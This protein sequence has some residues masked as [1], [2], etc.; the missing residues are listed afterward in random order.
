MRK[1]YFIFTMFFMGAV[2]AFAQGDDCANA[3]N[4][5]PASYVSDG[6]SSGNGASTSGTHSDWYKFTPLCDGIMSVGS[7]GGGVDT[8][9]YV[10]SGACGSLNQVGYADDNCTMGPGQS[11]FASTVVNLSVTGG[12]TYFI[13]W[14]DFWSSAPTPWYLD[15]TI[16]GGVNS[17]LVP[18]INEGYL[19]WIANGTEPGWDIQYGPDGFALGSGTSVN[20]DSAQG[21][22][23]TIPGLLPETTYCYYIAVENT[24]CYVGPIC[25]TTLPLCPEPTNL[26][27]NPLA[28]SAIL[29]WT[30]GG[31]TV[32][33]QQPSYTV[34]Y[35]PVGTPIDDAA[36]LY[37]STAGSSALNAQNLTSCTDYHLYIRETCDA[38]STPELQSLWVGP[39]TMTT[40][41]VCPEPDALTA[42]PTT[43]PFVYELGWN[44]NGTE[45]NWNIEWGV[46]GFI[47][48]SGTQVSVNS[49]PALVSG[50]TPDAII[51]YYV[52]A[53]CGGG[54]VSQWVGPFSFTSDPFCPDPTGLGATNITTVQANIFWNV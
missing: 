30:S 19:A 49:N 31:G 38:Q 54:D 47:L 29:N 20:V 37:N 16:A 17:S 8:R 15:F 44:I 24:G 5:T 9:L 45:T 22:S 42:D 46:A 6:A 50:I 34:Q 53:D 51:E 35:G 14:S 33:G 26:M 23:Y 28:N 32:P 7:C 48:G 18:G 12:T 41:C 11:N 4:V 2:T 10:H 36:M 21:T 1:I 39:I 13:E 25:F 43:D 40:A 3:V 52:Q 27:I